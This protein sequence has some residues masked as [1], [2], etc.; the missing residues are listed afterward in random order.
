M[1]WDKL[2]YDLSGYYADADFQFRYRRITNSAD[3]SYGGCLIDDV[4]LIKYTHTQ[5]TYF[6]DGT[7]MATPHV[8][9]L[10]SL[11]WNFRPNASSTQIRNA[12]IN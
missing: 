3:N 11:A 1:T 5:S 8:A 12:I 10:A 2:T 9:G 4:T 7:S 6:K